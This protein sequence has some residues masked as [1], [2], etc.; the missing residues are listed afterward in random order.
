MATLYIIPHCDDEL[1]CLGDIISNLKK[2]E[3]IF[4][5]LVCGNDSNRNGRFDEVFRKLQYANKQSKIY[6]SK[7]DIYPLFSHDFVNLS[8]DRFTIESQ[9]K[10]LFDKYSDIKRVVSCPDDGHTDH[11]FVNDLVRIS[12]R[13]DRNSMVDEVLEYFVP[14]SAKIG[15]IDKYNIFKTLSCHEVSYMFT[16]FELYVDVLFGV[17]AYKSYHK[18]LAYNGTLCGA[19]NA[20]RYK[21]VFKII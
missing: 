11:K 10:S 9:L 17:N 12:I 15:Q 13:P 18:F 16:Y 7:S 6:I 19:E 8:D 21:Q 14:G 3:D 1:F 2:Y 20:E 5:Y 4:V